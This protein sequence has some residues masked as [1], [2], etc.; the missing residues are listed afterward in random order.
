MTYQDRDRN[1]AY[2]LNSYT[3]KLLEANLG[4]A[5]TD[6]QGAEPIIPIAQQPE[7]MELGLPFLVYGS[8]IQ[9]AT[10][11]YALRTESL[12]YT[13]YAPTTTEVNRIINLL[14]EVYDRQDEAADD[15]NSWLA[16]EAPTRAGDRRQVTFGSVRTVMSERATPADEEGGFV[17]GFILLEMKYVPEAT[18]VQT[19]G[20]TNTP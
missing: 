12:S 14:A 11:L 3:W 13:I 4:W 7:F 20:F 19:S 17:S 16:V 5:K 8:S 9:P 1:A 15:V 10:H 18:T 2:A 6:Y